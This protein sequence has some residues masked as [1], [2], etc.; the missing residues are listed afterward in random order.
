MNTLRSHLISLLT[1]EQVKSDLDLTLV[2]SALF[3]ILPKHR[4]W[5]RKGVEDTSIRN[6]IADS[7]DIMLGQD[8][9]DILQYEWSNKKLSSCI[10]KPDYTLFSCDVQQSPVEVFVAEVKA[11]LRKKNSNG[12]IKRG[13]T[14]PHMLGLLVDGSQTNKRSTYYT[15]HMF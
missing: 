1:S 14:K 3:S 9:Q 15:K 8:N 2:V 4:T 13:M 12:F 11:P 7:F 5:E 6:Q 10:L